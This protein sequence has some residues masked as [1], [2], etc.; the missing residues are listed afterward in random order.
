MVSLGRRSLAI[1][2][3]MAMTALEII[4]KSRRD[5]VV[6]VEKQVAELE[7][8]IKDCSLTVKP[9]YETEK[10]VKEQRLARL[11]GDVK[12]LEAEIARLNPELPG[13]PPKN[14]R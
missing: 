14:K 10:K 5:S 2:G 6:K 9:V 12:A 11:L 1:H 13:I 3:K 4:L 7:Q 8:A